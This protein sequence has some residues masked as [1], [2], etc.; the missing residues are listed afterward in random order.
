MYVRRRAGGGGTHLSPCLGIPLDV[1]G[2]GGLEVS[3]GAHLQVV[4]LLRLHLRCDVA[5]MLHLNVLRELGQVRRRV[6][7]SAYV[8]AGVPA[9]PSRASGAVV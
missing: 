8:E 3:S 9:P 4:A 2:L 7:A 5:P 1:R 6:A